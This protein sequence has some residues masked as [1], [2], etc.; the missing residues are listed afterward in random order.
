MGNPSIRVNIPRNPKEFLDLAGQ[1]LKRHTELAENSP[2]NA[3]VS[4]KWS[5]N[6]PKV[7]EAL[8]LHFQA[9]E[10]K[11]KS[12]EAVN[13]RNVLIAELNDSVKASRDLLIGVYRETP[14]TLGDFGFVVD[15]SVRAK[16]KTDVQP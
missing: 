7:A 9:E 13:K 10:L 6:G 5:D 1:I 8:A 3:L 12:E 2:L 15:D 4:H 16:V 11:R 14:K